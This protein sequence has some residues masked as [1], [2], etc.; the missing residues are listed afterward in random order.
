ME[1]K[2]P[3]VFQKYRNYREEIDP[4]ITRKE[5]KT[6]KQ[7]YKN[8]NDPFFLYRKM[9]ETPGET[10]QQV[11][12]Y[13][14]FDSLP[15]LTRIKSRKREQTAE[16][17]YAAMQKKFENTYNNYV[18][19]LVSAG[20]SEED[21]DEQFWSEYYPKSEMKQL[22]DYNEFQQRRALGNVQGEEP[23]E[24]VSP[25]LSY[26]FPPTAIPKYVADETAGLLTGERKF[27]DYASNMA[28]MAATGMIGRIQSA[29]KAAKTAWK[30]YNSTKKT[31][32][33]PK[34]EPKVEI[35]NLEY[36]LNQSFLLGSTEDAKKYADVLNKK[37][38]IPYGATRRYGNGRGSF[39]FGN[40]SSDVY[41][42][43]DLL[44][45][46]QVVKGLTE[47]DFR[48]ARKTSGFKNSI[49]KNANPKD[50][51]KINLEKLL[52]AE[53][54]QFGNS[55]LYEQVLSQINQTRKF[56]NAANKAGINLYYNPNTVKLHQHMLPFAAGNIREGRPFMKQLGSV[57]SSSAI[58]PTAI[59]GIPTGIGAII[60]KQKQYH[61]W[62]NAA[63]QLSN[64]GWLFQSYFNNHPNVLN[65]LNSILD[66]YKSDPNNEEYKYYMEQAD[67]NYKDIPGYENYKRDYLNNN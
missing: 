33:P 53:S 22:H 65:E 18:G 59:V 66:S 61:D 16:N 5:W 40:I 6:A 12:I 2:Y 46:K 28:E 10:L 32:P 44:D 42:P 38:R 48:T 37:G 27:G 8:A 13:P 1:K 57:V 47:K 7:N 43:K 39:W 45:P 51:Y 50:Y 4:D 64:E 49:G 54:P 15:E 3:Y 60:S 67:K 14:E 23:I 63:N 24:T 52:T 29:G 21:A 11:S 55:K 25:F 9:Q 36:D 17:D 26:L 34:T 30:N 41:I 19:S 31:P 56:E 62:L 35:S 58:A 20:M